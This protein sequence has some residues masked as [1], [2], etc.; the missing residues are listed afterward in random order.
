M[1]NDIIPDHTI[2]VNYNAGK[3]GY[4]ISEYNIIRNVYTR[5]Y[6]AFFAYPGTRT[7]ISESA[8]IAIVANFGSGMNKA[9]LLNAAFVQFDGIISFQQNSNGTISILNTDQGR[10]Y[11]FGGYKIVVHQYC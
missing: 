4:I 9:W 2:K 1:H 3:Q 7:D 5:I 8:D 10:L 6:F 11:R